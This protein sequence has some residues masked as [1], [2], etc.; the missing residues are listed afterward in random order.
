M[1]H[2]VAAKWGDLGVRL[3]SAAV[4]IPAVL[5]NVWV[6]GLWFSLLVA[7]LGVLMALE[8]TNMAHQRDPLQFAL[9]AAA[10]L[11]GAFL[12]LPIGI[13]GA[14]AA[15]GV[16]WALSA[17][18]AWFQDRQGAA[19]QYLGIPYVG[20]PAI[21]F[22]LLRSDATHGISAILWVLVIV[23]A[24]DTL[25][26]FGGKLIGGPK[27]APIISPKK[28][29]AGLGGAVAGGAVASAI[30][31]A[32]TGLGAVTILSLLAGLLALAAQGGDLFKSALKR[33]CGV[34]DSGRLIPGHGGV[35]DRVDGLVAVAMVAALIGAAR[36]GPGAT[37]TGLLLW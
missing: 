6:G 23:W 14:A 27:L 37:G 31:A 4:L 36:S 33:H 10:A 2:P 26:Y 22:V 35:I 21:A 34:K 15:I 13:A 8:W 7:L 30:F 1:Q 9:H 28:T 29:W 32:L 18:V 3:L 24:A 11:C 12:P 17:A 16:L 5:I 19:W 20:V 25:A